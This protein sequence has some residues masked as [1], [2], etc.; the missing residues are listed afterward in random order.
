MN[1]SLRRCRIVA[2]VLVLA[3]AGCRFGVGL[4]GVGFGMG[5][6]SVADGVNETADP[7][8]LRVDSQD[9]AITVHDDLTCDAVAETTR[10]ILTPAGVAAGQRADVTFDPVTQ[11]ADLV[12]AYVTRPDG[13]RVDV[14]KENVFTRPSA[15]AQDTPGFANGRTT[16]VVFPQL[17]VGTVTHVKWKFSDRS[18][19][20]LGFSY[21]WRPTF[22]LAVE[23]AH[24]SVTAPANVN[25]RSAGRNGFDVKE[26]KNENGTITVNGTLH[27]YAAGRREPGM[28]SPKDV[29]PAFAVSTIPS[30]EAIGAKFRESS[31][32]SVESTPE[33]AA[34]AAEIAGD[35]KGGDAA[36]AICL[37]VT[38]NINY[39]AVRLDSADAWVPHRA[40]DVL[41][42]GYGDC[43]DQ[44]A[45]LASLL[46]ARNIASEAVLVGRD[47]GLDPLPVPT[48]RQFD[49]CITYL[50]E[51][52]VYVDPT[53]SFCDFGVLDLSLRGKFVVHA[54]ETG[55]TS[56]TPVG[57]ADRN[58]YAIAN[59]VKLTANG[60]IEGLSEIGA[61]G[62]PAQLM[63]QILAARDGDTLAA[64]L[65]L[66]TPEGGEGTVTSTDPTDLSVPFQ[67]RGRWRSE[68]AV[69]MGPAV[70]F[71]PPSGI[72]YANPMRA[73]RLLADTDRQYPAMVSPADF[74]WVNGVEL[75]PGYD[76]TRLPKGKSVE[77]NAGSYTSKWLVESPGH[78]R[79]E[80]HLRIDAELIPP[81]DFPELRRLLDAFTSDSREVVVLRGPSAQ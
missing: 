13:M 17:G 57:R 41:R 14:T 80:R 33:I 32:A 2:P 7:E 11:S 29:V 37:W 67:C 79:I 48:P 52:D 53:N 62:R 47:G 40:S 42:N 46:A 25:L 26:T 12:E 4:G 44:Y 74:M 43:K 24:V 54:T 61:T 71:T 8:G 15:A 23:N 49:H 9:I 10:T 69:E 18:R 68:N 3:A 77:T 59:A 55:K 5:V 28:I 63:R 36:R 56:R 45:L 81:G 60:T 22:S 70:F 34:R 30:W 78:I 39:V 66:Q 31:A 58:T 27:G 65:L 75:P 21:V 1:P 35:R 72:D 64:D 19:S 6:G 16:S 73:R 50:P 76:V 38:R 51:L 20:S